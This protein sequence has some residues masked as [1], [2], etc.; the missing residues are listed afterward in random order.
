M[1]AVKSFGESRECGLGYSTAEQGSFGD[2][3]PKLGH[4][5]IRAVDGHIHVLQMDVNKA[6]YY[7]GESGHVYGQ[8]PPEQR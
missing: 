1:R 5:W 3:F 2:S 6:I 4:F 8:E 7:S